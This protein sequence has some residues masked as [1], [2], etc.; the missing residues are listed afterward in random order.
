MDAVGGGVRLLAWSHPL[1]S[2]RIDRAAPEGAS[3]AEIV[4]LA[5]LGHE[6]IKVFS[7]LGAV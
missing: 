7:R 3:L 5:A 2:D 1:R 4:A 6:P